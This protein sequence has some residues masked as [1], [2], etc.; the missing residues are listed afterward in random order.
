MNN[1]TIFIIQSLIDFARELLYFPVWWYTRGAINTGKFLLNFLKMVEK[2]FAL[3]IWIKNIFKPMYSQHDIAG[4][5]IS[6]LVRSV[7]IVFRGIIMTVISFLTLGIFLGWLI[8][9]AI[10]INGIFL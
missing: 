10:V 8:L 3:W 1:Y 5:I 4:I 9:P 2:Y 7:Q 6:F